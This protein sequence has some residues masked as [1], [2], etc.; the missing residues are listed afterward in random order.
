MQDVD[1]KKFGASFTLLEQSFS[2]WFNQL[3]DLNYTMRQFLSRENQDNPVQGVRVL[4]TQINETINKVVNRKLLGPLQQSNTKP[5]LPKTAYIKYSYE[6]QVL[7]LEIRII[8][9]RQCINLMYYRLIYGCKKMLRSLHKKL[10][11][12]LTITEVGNQNGE[13]QHQIWLNHYSQ[14]QNSKLYKSFFETLLN[15]YQFSWEKYHDLKQVAKNLQKHMR[16]LLGAHKTLKS[17]QLGPSDVQGLLTQ[18]SRN[19]LESFGHISTEQEWPGNEKEDCRFY[20]N[21]KCIFIVFVLHDP[22]VYKLISEVHDLVIDDL[23][24]QHHSTSDSYNQNLS[25]SDIGKEC[26]AEELREIVK[27]ITKF[28]TGETQ[29]AQ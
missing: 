12:I 14:G 22:L 19:L 3:N 28:R 27:H 23:I 6:F 7:E 11:P 18:K 1:F 9:L 8:L 15:Y 24:K 21:A 10:Q 26:I 17:T 29:L 4:L 13:T 20:R 25:K 2:F 16:H 5:N